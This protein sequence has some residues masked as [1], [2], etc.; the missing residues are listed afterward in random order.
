MDRVLNKLPFI[1][2][3]NGFDLGRPDLSASFVSA[4]AVQKVENS[5]NVTGN[6]LRFVDHEDD[7]TPSL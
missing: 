7:H 5:L 2:A 6:R 4:V 3:N 1:Q